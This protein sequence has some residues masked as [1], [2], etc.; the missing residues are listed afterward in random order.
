MYKNSSLYFIREQKRKEFVTLVLFLK[1]NFLT[2][3]DYK[4]GNYIYLYRANIY[5]A[6][7]Q[8]DLRRYVILENDL[9][10]INLN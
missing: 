3:C 10:G 2:R 4:D 8:K 7:R 9:K 6:D 5:M 1:Q